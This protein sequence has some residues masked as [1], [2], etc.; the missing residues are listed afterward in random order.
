MLGGLLWELEPGELPAGALLV[1]QE[2]QVPSPAWLPSRSIPGFGT[3]APPPARTPVVDSPIVKGT[4]FL[5]VAAVRSALTEGVGVTEGS[6]L[7][8][9]QTF[10][11]TTSCFLFL[12]HHVRAGLA[13]PL[14]EKFALGCPGLRMQVWNLGACPL[15]APP[16]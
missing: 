5:E 4:E 16:F 7:L 12:V 13:S 11:Q 9:E 14:P 10:L 2:P 3:P 8:C 1:L 6:S 15:A